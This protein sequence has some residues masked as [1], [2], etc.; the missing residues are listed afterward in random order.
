LADGYY[1]IVC[2]EIK[3]LGFCFDRH[4]K[5]SHE[6]WT[7]GKISLLVARNMKSRHTAKAIL[8][9]AGSSKKL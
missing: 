4:A 1:K 2:K 7:N 9:N 5:G 3:Q 6:F 8:K